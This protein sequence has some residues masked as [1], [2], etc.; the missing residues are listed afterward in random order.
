[1]SDA[2]LQDRTF[3]RAARTTAGAYPPPRRL[4]SYAAEG[5]L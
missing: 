2:G 5:A 3:A 4:L 1:M